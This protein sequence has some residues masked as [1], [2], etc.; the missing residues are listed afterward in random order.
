M[1]EPTPAAAYATAATAE[2]ERAAAA[3]DAQVAARALETA[4]RAALA[5]PPVP[6]ASSLVDAFAARPRLVARAASLLGMYAE[7]DGA[8]A[9]PWILF[10]RSGYQ[11][12]LDAGAWEVPPLDAF[13]LADSD[14]EVH[15]LLGRVE[16]P[17]DEIPRN[18]PPSHTWWPQR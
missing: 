16:I 14:E 6:L 10:A 1:S 18:V 13:H 12:L 11:A 9:V 5:H 2:I 8:E 7:M 3:D 15:A 4:G 17:P